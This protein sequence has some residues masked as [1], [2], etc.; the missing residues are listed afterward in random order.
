[1]ALILQSIRVSSRLQGA[2]L[3][4]PSNVTTMQTPPIDPPLSAKVA[5]LSRP[6]A[7]GAAVTRVDVIETHMSLLF[8]T[9]QHV[10][11]LKKPISN[12]LMDF[13]TTAAR[14]RNAIEEVRLNQRLAAT[15][16][17]AVIPLSFTERNGFVLR[18]ESH[19]VDWLVLMRRLPA[20]Q[21]LDQ[22]LQAN[23]IDRDEIEGIAALL[24]CF[25]AN[26]AAVAI[27]EQEYLARF[28]QV[29][30]I[31][32]AEL[33]APMYQL[34]TTRIGSLCQLH[35]DFLQQHPLRLTQRAAAQRI[36]EAHGDLR[37]EH[38]CVDKPPVAI[39]CLEFNRAL[40]LLDPVDEL[41]YLS[42]ECELL[43]PTMA[44][45]IE[46][47]LFAVYRQHCHDAAEP[48]LICF[49]KSVRATTR[50]RLMVLHLRDHPETQWPKWLGKAHAYLQ[51]AEKY[52]SLFEQFHD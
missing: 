28:E 2:T 23:F 45:G 47:S 34:D 21:M 9:E 1:M 7:Y 36:I 12:Q 50:A 22:R 38:I 33:S 40:R 49:Y 31:N 41:A 43:A 18:G 39:D 26:A 6:Q 46:Q 15:V 17:L 13:S 37:P 44:V 27:S 11:K 29:I 14:H 48:A 19:V 42:M 25:Y 8:L 52:A 20:R 4:K 30:A 51:L 32:R 16:Y 35:A 24:A 5:F 3:G 10:Y